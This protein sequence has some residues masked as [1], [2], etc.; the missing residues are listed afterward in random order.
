M[1]AM[2]QIVE[3]EEG[4]FGVWLTYLICSAG[5]TIYRLVQSQ[6]WP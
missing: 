4:S 2:M 3:E 5:E 1:L 6:L